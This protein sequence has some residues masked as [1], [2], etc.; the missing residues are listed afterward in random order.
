VVL[1]DSKRVTKS[2]PHRIYLQRA[3]V[4]RRLSVFLLLLYF[5]VLVD[6][7]SGIFLDSVNGVYS[8]GIAVWLFP[9]PSVGL[10]MVPAYVP[11]T[12]ID[13]IIY[14][15]F[16]NQGI[17]IAWMLPSI[18]YIIMPLPLWA[19]RTFA[20]PISR[21]V[22]IQHE[23]EEKVGILTSAIAIFSILLSVATFSFELNL[24]HY[25]PIPL[26]LVLGISVTLVFAILYEVLKRFQR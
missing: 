5:A 17:W 12:Q 1:E 15:V 2:T 23:K 4:V 8:G 16:I 9:I 25:G 20:R 24:G 3:L 11:L 26:V 6:A 14:L 18:I 13:V 10:R 22:E 21:P 19:Y 7:G